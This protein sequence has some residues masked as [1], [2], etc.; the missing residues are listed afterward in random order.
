[1]ADEIY[2]DEFLYRGRSKS[3]DIPPAWHIVLGSVGIDGFG[4][5]TRSLNGPLNETQATAAGYTLASIIPALNIDTLKAH[6]ELQAI[7]ATQIQQID[8]LQNRLAMSNEA[9][10]AL[11]TE[12]N[13][14]MQAN[15][16]AVASAESTID[17]LNK[18]LTDLQTEY[19]ALNANNKTTL[20]DVARFQ[21]ERDAVVSNSAV[22]TQNL[23][24]LRAEYATSETTLQN[25]R[26]T[27]TALQAQLAAKEQQTEA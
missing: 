14:S 10:T 25:T 15:D 6:D 26:D 20:A 7:N 9:N 24:D 17:A 23:S 3:D 13:Y 18:K 11:Q 16:A 27:V 2:I 8:D 12:Y 19:E 5:K 22:I 4:N 1:M 21:S